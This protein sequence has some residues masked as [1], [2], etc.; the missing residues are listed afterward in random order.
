MSR[1]ERKEARAA[2]GT[3]RSPSERDDSASF[4]LLLGK[5]KHV[6]RS[7]Q[8]LCP[9][10]PSVAG[11]PGHCGG[12]LDGR[13]G[14]RAGS[15]GRPCP[16]W[17][18]PP[19]RLA[20][21]PAPAAACGFCV[22]HC[23]DTRRSVC[24]VLVTASCALPRGSHV[25]ATTTD[26]RSLGAHPCL[27]W[28]DPSSGSRGDALS[29]KRWEPFRPLRRQHPLPSLSRGLRPPCCLICG[30]SASATRPGAP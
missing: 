7:A 22:R 9:Q 14:S 4:L 19:P 21:R 30:P 12:Y 5:G 3:L 16:A 11:C 15:G 25:G 13:D 18:S 1:P 24:E 8:K 27:T 2:S 6:S 20:R 10:G 26:S 29:P 28:A 17:L 23:T